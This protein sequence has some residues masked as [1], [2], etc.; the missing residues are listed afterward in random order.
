MVPGYYEDGGTHQLQ[1][2][3]ML[4]SRRAVKLIEVAKT[5]SASERAAKCKEMFA[6]V[7]HAHT[8]AYR[9]ILRHAEGPFQP[10]MSSTGMSG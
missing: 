10:G 6:A 9:V 3:Q 4:S 8:N 5:L 1:L 2:L 7:F